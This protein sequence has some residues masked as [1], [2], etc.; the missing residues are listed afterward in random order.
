MCWINYNIEY[1]TKVIE[2]I[3]QSF[4][5][6]LTTEINTEYEKR[7]LFQIRFTKIAWILYKE[8]FSVNPY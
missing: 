8:R 3:L 2:Y 5:E 6:T 4:F 7:I 1:F